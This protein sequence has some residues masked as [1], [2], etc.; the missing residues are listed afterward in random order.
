M[1]PSKMEVKKET[2]FAFPWHCF[3]RVKLALEDVVY[4]PK[5]QVL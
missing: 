3:S 2:L 1:K 4:F 5:Y